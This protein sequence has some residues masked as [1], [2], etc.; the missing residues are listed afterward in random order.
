MLNSSSKSLVKLKWFENEDLVISF[1]D[2][3]MDDIVIRK[4]TS[5]SPKGGTEARKLLAASLAKCMSSTLFSLLKSNNVEFSNFTVNAETV[6]G[7]GDNGTLHV[8]S[9]NLTI[10]LNLPHDEVTRRKFKGI[11]KIFDRGCLLSRSLKNG[12]SINTNI[13]V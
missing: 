2:D 7:E 9:I 6:T 3:N 12:V 10:S 4:P 1:N 13:K 8:H 5:P 11:K